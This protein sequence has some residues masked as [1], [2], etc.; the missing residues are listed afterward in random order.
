MGRAT[1]TAEASTAWRRAATACWVGVGLDGLAG[2]EHRDLRVPRDSFWLSAA[3][4]WTRSV[5]PALTAWLRETRATTPN[6][7]ATTATTRLTVASV[8]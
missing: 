4:A 6:P 3:R 7:T 8:R 2:Q 5:R 1:R